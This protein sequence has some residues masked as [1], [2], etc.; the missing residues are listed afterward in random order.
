[1]TRQKNIDRNL[2][3][4][5][6]SVP[7]L[8]S[9]MSA[10]HLINMVELGNPFFM[11][12]VLAV[13]FEL[14]SIV[15]F[16]ALSKN[17]LKRLKKDIL[18][19]I[20]GMLFVLQAF[21]NVYSSFDYIRVMLLSDP[22]WL[23]SFREMFFNAMDVSTSKL[24]LSCI[25]GLPIPII[26]LA[27]LK[28]AID[29]F[30]FDGTE[31]APAEKLDYSPQNAYED[32]KQTEKPVAEKKTDVKS[33]KSSES[34]AQP[35]FSLYENDGNA[36][37]PADDAQDEP[38]AE[39]LQTETHDDPVFKS[40][41]VFTIEPPPY[42][43]LQR[44]FETPDEPVLENEPVSQLA[45]EIASEEPEQA[46]IEEPAAQASQQVEETAPEAQEHVEQEVTAEQEKQDAQVQ[47]ITV[48]AQ[49]D[50]LE[51]KSS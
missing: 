19:L 35:R 33:E 7:L 5:F 24:M 20:F 15:S 12:V 3:F 47:V 42:R 4:A 41:G 27:F 2:L 10:I 38:V 11:A 45:E 31:E 40:P 36:Y 34:V 18:Y 25:I 17:I 46:Q 37:T 28:S 13:T 51:K 16:V 39:Q 30:S 44:R 9:I 26:S 32:S 48:Q 14:G 29:Y 50:Q 22:T 21:G 43:E 8:S 49:P 23:D 6:L 1:M